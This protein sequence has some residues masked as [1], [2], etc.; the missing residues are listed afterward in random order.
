MFPSCLHIILQSVLLWQ[1]K[2]RINIFLVSDRVYTYDVHTI[3]LQTFF[4][5]ACKIVVD[6]WK[7]SMLLQYILWDEWP[8]FMISGTNEQLQQQLK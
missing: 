2:V 3:S 8:I 7:F 6:S 1:T 5:W 4:V